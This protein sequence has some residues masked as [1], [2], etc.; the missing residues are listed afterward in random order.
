MHDLQSCKA[1]LYAVEEESRRC[2]GRK[3]VRI[4]LSIGALSGTE[5]EH[6][7]ETL[8]FCSL[9]TIAEG[10]ELEVVERPARI[11]CLD[12]DSIFETDR[13]GVPNCR[14]CNSSQTRIID[15]DGL[16]LESLEIETE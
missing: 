7:K 4:R 3:V 12:C 2:K 13:A 15:G 5:P 9:G 11:R 16:I 1:V 14:R 10:A 6:L 8:A